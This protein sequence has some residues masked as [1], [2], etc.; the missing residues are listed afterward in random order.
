MTVDSLSEAL[1]VWPDV[2]TIDVEGHEQHV[3]AG[4]TRA[5]DLAR[6]DVH[7]AMHPPE[8][9]ADHDAVEATMTGA[10]YV[11]TLQWAD[12][13]GHDVWTPEERTP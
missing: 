5:L 2:I 8:F 6:P 13:E 7:V 11:R 12:H 3:L 9:G 10:G 1:D 4:A